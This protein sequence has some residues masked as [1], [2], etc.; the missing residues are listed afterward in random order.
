[1]HAA[2]LRRHG[3]PEVLEVGEIPTPTPKEGEILVRVKAAA[4]N[5]LDLWVRGGLP[6]LKLAYPHILGADCAG[7]VDKTGEPVILYP[8]LSCGKCAHCTSGIESLCAEYRILGEHVSGTHAQYVCVPER[9][10]F[11][12]PPNLS[13]EEAAAIPLVYVTAWEMV[14]RKAAVKE[15]DWVLIHG[16]GSGVS[17]AAIQI[18]AVLKA[19]VI[20]TSGDEKKLEKARA[21]G[22]SHVVCTKS[23]DF[24]PQVKRLCPKG[25]DV[26]VDHVGQAFWESNVK[27]LKSGGTLVTCGATSGFGAKT[28]LRHLFF[29]QL[30]LLGSTMGS[31]RD[32][33]AILDLVAGGKLKGV[34]D[35]AFPLTEAMAAHGYLEE[36]KQFGKVLLIP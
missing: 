9:N 27:V 30:R 36:G 5:H 21:L 32:F 31:R 35:R 19:N 18:A 20:A 13:F 17:S 4:L 8:A 12:K 29:R 16:A 7:I 15:G 25:V 22:A 34:V 1:M 3:G 11:P 28:D 26:V 14:V 24:A 33:P 6:N 23:G 10:L 2:F